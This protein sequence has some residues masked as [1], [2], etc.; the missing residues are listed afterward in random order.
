M[1]GEYYMTGR[2]DRLKGKREADIKRKKT[3][4]MDIFL[5]IRFFWKS[6]TKKSMQA[7]GIKCL[8]TAWTT[9]IFRPSSQVRPRNIISVCGVVVVY[10]L[11]SC[12]DLSSVQKRRKIFQCPLRSGIV[13]L[14]A[15]RRPKLRNKKKRSRSRK[16]NFMALYRRQMAL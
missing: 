13:F 7:E 11:K 12:F 1:Q 8:T 2:W 6:Q 15:I 9:L 4:I 10:F 16:D 5:N 3:I 14:M